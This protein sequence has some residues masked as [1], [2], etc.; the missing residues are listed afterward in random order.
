MKHQTLGL[1]ELNNLE[2]ILAVMEE[3]NFSTA[4]FFKMHVAF[5]V[6]LVTVCV[7]FNKLL[8]TGHICI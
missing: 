3:N 2:F 7:V 4:L 6:L 8:I 1:K 5:Y